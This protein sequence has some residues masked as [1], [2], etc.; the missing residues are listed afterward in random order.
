MNGMRVV[1]GEGAASLRGRVVAEKEGAS[2]PDRLRIHLTPAE[3]DSANDTLRFFDAEIQSDG[4]FKL[5]N[6]PPGRYMLFTRQRTEEE[7]KQRSPRP[8]AWNA[9]ARAVLH[10]LAQAANTTIELKPCQRIADYKFR[11]SS[12]KEGAGRRP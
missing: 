12:L 2:L 11:Y 5:T 8:M 10:R 3:P 1:L 6:L 7:A 9:T 4:S